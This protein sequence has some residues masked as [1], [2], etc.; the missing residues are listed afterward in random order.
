MPYCQKVWLAKRGSGCIKPAVQG[1]QNTTNEPSA[2]VSLIRGQAP[3]VLRQTFTVGMPG[4]SRVTGCTGAATATEW[5]VHRGVHIIQQTVLERPQPSPTTTAAATAAP[6]LGQAHA[7]AHAQLR[8]TFKPDATPG[9]RLIFTSQ[10]DYTG[11]ASMVGFCSDNLC[12]SHLLI[13]WQRQPFVQNYL[14]TFGTEQSKRYRSGSG[15]TR[16]MRKLLYIE[17]E[18]LRRSAHL[19]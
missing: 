19:Y 6:R 2:I 7:H 16:N 13:A 1:A 15:K 4:D 5:G 18:L 14:H 11:A 17:A 10:A 9:D 12:H 3:T 8:A